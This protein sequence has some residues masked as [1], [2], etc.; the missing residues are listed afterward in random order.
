MSADPRHVVVTTTTGTSNT[1]GM[2][3]KTVGYLTGVWCGP[4]PKP[5]PVG[6]LNKRCTCK[7][8]QKRRKRHASEG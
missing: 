1:P 2:T 7:G 6:L 5:K 4:P 8:C 3:T